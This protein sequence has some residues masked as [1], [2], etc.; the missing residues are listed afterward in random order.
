[1]NSIEAAIAF[2][3]AS[4]L[5]GIVAESSPLQGRV[6]QVVDEAHKHGLYLFT[7]G[8]KNNDLAFVNEQRKCGVD[9]VIS[10]DLFRFHRCAVAAAFS[11]WRRCSVGGA[12]KPCLLVTALSAPSSPPRRP[13]AL[14]RPW[15]LLQGIDDA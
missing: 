15:V 14:R 9:A 8:A 3:R 12:R 11:S 5:Q 1:M 13:V 10:D 2:S 4:M 6:K 7:W